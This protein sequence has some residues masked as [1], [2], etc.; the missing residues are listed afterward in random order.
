MTT[1]LRVQYSAR[2]L[3]ME[4]TYVHDIYAKGYDGRRGE[5]D[6]VLIRV[7]LGMRSSLVG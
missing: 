2:V 4:N 3:G 5:G 6:E 1:R 7:H